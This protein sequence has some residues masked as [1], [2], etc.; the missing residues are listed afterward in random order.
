MR[1]LRVPKGPLRRSLRQRCRP[2]RVR[3]KAFGPRTHPPFGRAARPRDVA[4]FRTWCSPATSWPADCAKLRATSQSMARS[5]GCPGSSP[6]CATRSPAPA[7]SGSK[8]CS[9]PCRAWFAT[10]PPE[11]GKQVLV[12][13]DGGDVELDREMIE[14]IRDP[15]THIIRNA[16]DHGIETAGRA[17]ERRQA[18]NRPAVRLARASRATRS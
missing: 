17:T 14:M 11:L 10:C 9:S 6:R 13:I 8:I 2:K 18:R 16:V 1:S 4:A 3:S 5:S 7:C 12:D 15:L